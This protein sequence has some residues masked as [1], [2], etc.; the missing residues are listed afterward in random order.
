MLGILFLRFSSPTEPA[1]RA[2]LRR[3]L[4]AKTSKE[5]SSFLFR[6]YPPFIRL[7][8][9]NGRNFIETKREQLLLLLRH[10]SKSKL[11]TL[12]RFEFYRS[13]LTRRKEWIV[14]GP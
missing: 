10:L 1:A 13:M 14:V 3:F 7:S 9:R 11:I 2:R 4:R 5:E 12:F 6:F 8:V